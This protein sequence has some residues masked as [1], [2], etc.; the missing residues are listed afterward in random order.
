MGRRRGRQTWRRLFAS[1]AGT[2]VGCDP[3]RRRFGGAL[4][5][6]VAARDQTCRDPSGDAPIRHLDHVQRFVDGG[7]TTLASGRGVCARHN[8]IRELPGWKVVVVHDGWGEEPHTIR[9]TTPT[10]HSCLCRALDPP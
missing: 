8:L 7:S 3:H 9:V 6:L 1:A 4:A 2:L 5:R 10:G